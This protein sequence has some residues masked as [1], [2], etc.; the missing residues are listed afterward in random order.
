[1][2]VAQ[3]SLCFWHFHKREEDVSNLTLHLPWAPNANRFLGEQD[4]Y[5]D[6]LLMRH[7]SSYCE[8]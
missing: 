7:T 2:K 3:T 1:M 8:V 4:D 6:V 5:S